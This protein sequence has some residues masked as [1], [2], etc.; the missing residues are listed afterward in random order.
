MRSLF[1]FSV[2][3]NHI[4]V[5]AF[6]NRNVDCFIL[7]YDLT[8]FQVSVQVKQLAFVDFLDFSGGYF[9]KPAV[10][11]ASKH[12]IVTNLFCSF[13]EGERQPNLKKI[14]IDQRILI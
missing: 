12:R 3:I 2:H 13:S 1:L 10:S 6:D 7:I 9:T 14:A 4:G 11:A 5:I 8:H